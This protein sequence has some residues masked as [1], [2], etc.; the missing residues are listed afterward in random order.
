MKNGNLNKHRMLNKLWVVILLEPKRKIWMINSHLQ[1]D[2]S[3]SIV[4]IAKSEEMRKRKCM[5]IL[6][7]W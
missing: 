3:L 6:L 7:Y 1:V 4:K 2:G 5:L